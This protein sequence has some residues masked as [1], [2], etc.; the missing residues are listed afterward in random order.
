MEDLNGI[1]M[2]NIT[3]EILKSN[4]FVYCYKLKVCKVICLSRYLHY[5]LCILMTRFYNA[6]TPKEKCKNRMH[7]YYLSH[8]SLF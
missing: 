6:L 1:R 5:H 4:T 3:I 2:V 8:T 7:F